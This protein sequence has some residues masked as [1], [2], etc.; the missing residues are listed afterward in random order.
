MKKIILILIFLPLSYSA[1]EIVKQQD[2]SI[3][4]CYISLQ[5]ITQQLYK[6]KSYA[7]KMPINQELQVE[8]EKALSQTNSFN[9]EFDSLKKDISILKSSDNKLRIICWDIKKDDGTY[10]YY[11]FIQYKHTSKKPKKESVLLFPLIDYST[12]IKNPDNHISDNKK[13]LGMWYYNIITKK[14]KSKTYYTLLA[15]DGNDKFSQKKIIDILTFDNAG[16]PKFGNDI[17]VFGKKFPKRVILEYSQDCT[18]SLKYNAKKDS[19]FFD[20]LAPSNPSLQGQFQYYCP[21]MSYD[22]FGFKKGK[23]YYKAD[24]NATNDKND[25]DKFYN[26]P[27]KLKDNQQKESDTLIKREKPKEKKKE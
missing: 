26:D 16:N 14:H 17:F 8:F 27:T 25:K 10:I 21:D 20:H 22:G 6:A 1:Q 4:E 13:W 18:M 11:G 2:K 19:I 9:F 24:V 15:W 12:E 5:E 23:W 3:E 7:D